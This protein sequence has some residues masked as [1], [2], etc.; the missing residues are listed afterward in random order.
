MLWYAL[1]LWSSNV[2][3]HK[4]NTINRQKTGN[5]QSVSQSSAKR[6]AALPCRVAIKKKGFS[7]DNFFE[8]PFCRSPSHEKSRHTVIYDLW[9]IMSLGTFFPICSWDF[10]DVSSSQCKHLSFCQTPAS[11]QPRNFGWYE[12]HM[13]VD[14]SLLSATPRRYFNHTF[15]ASFSLLLN[16]PDRCG[17]HH[18]FPF[19]F[20]EPWGNSSTLLLRA[21]SKKTIDQAASLFT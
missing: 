14:S 1:F 15:S 4:S 16:E 21:F 2:Q 18:L 11:I 6:D 17:T 5:P 7:R 9:V 13:T 10:G 8:T 3:F 12:L 19:S 20:S